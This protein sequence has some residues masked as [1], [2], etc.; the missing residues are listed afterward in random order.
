MQQIL[1]AVRMLIVLTL[2][3]GGLYPV[4]VT[5]IANAVFPSQSRGSIQ[6]A[7]N[8]QEVGSALFGQPFADPRYFQPRPSGTGYSGFVAPTDTSSASGASSGTNYSLINPSLKEAVDNRA[9]EFRTANG[10]ATD[11]PVP[12][13]MLFASGSGLD[14]HISPEAARLQI[15]R[16]ATARGKSPDEIAAIVE[17]FVEP[18]QLVVFGQ[19]RVNVLLL[20]LE[21]DKS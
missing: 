13:D 21:L 14:P 17:R 18:P 20:N 6:T 11:A 4:V 15:D 16:V 1:P 8:G 19:P 3:T 10:L 9:A 12:V 2:L 7:T 5:L